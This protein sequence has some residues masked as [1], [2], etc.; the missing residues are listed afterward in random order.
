[1]R[2]IRSFINICILIFI[3]QINLAAQNKVKIIGQFVDSISR[4][5]IGKVSFSLYQN[6]SIL[7]HSLSNE[8]GFF[9]LNI[10]TNSKTFKVRFT[11][12]NYLPRTV[13][14][15][16]Q[17][18]SAL[19]LGIIDLKQ[20]SIS[21]K[22]VNIISNST[23]I[24]EK[25]D[26]TLTA[27]FS[28]HQFKSY[29][30]T[31]KAL[32]IIPGI[33]VANSKVYLNGVEID[34]IRVGDRNFIFDK[35]FL[36]Q[37]LPGFTIS[38]VKIIEMT[39]DFGRKYNR[40]N[41]ILKSVDQSA[42]LFNSNLSKGTNSSNWASLSS[43]RIDSLYQVGVRI[44]HNNINIFS[45]AWDTESLT[46]PINIPGLNMLTTVDISAFYQ[47]DKKTS[48]DFKY[49]NNEQNSKVKQENSIINLVSKD[50][51]E[52]KLEN[53][54]EN[55]NEFQN[56]NFLTKKK[57]NHLT[58]ISIGNETKISD[59]KS[60]NVSNFFINYSNLNSTSTRN[61]KGKDVEF[62]LNIDRLKKSQK[63]PFFNLEVRAEIKQ[64]RNLDKLIENLLES[65][66][67]RNVNISHAEASYKMNLNIGKSILLQAYTNNN[68]GKFT[69]DDKVAGS[70]NVDINSLQSS[71]G[72]KLVRKKNNS[73]I[74]IDLSHITYILK[75]DSYN[76]THINA[77]SSNINYSNQ[78]KNRNKISVTFSNDYSLPTVNQITGIPNFGEQ[79]ILNVKSNFDL[80]P[81]KRYNFGITYSLKTS[82]TLDV[83]T[84]YV[85]NKI[86][87][88]FIT[89]P[90]K[91]PELQYINSNGTKG[92][93][94]NLS[95]TKKAS[96]DE[97]YITGTIG[98]KYSES[99]YFS[100][101]GTFPNN[102]FS[103]FLN[104]TYNYSPLK[105]MK[106]N[107]ISEFSTIYYFNVNQSRNSTLSNTVLT[108][109]ELGDRCDISAEFK[110]RNY[111][112]G[113]DVNMSS[114]IINLIITNKLFASRS[115]GVFVSANNI[116]NSDNGQ[117]ILSSIDR[118][119]YFKTNSLGRYFLFGINYKISTFK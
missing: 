54:I 74:N 58:S 29:V 101:A 63:A 36:L 88:I 49:R 17:K 60:N 112:S 79:P 91:L 32:Q 114:R 65:T 90:T 5:G 28:K 44:Q 106:L 26:D 14:I 48:I 64:G 6:D 34:D 109:Y 56:F 53:K 85:Q 100:E 45:D 2:L 102:V 76:N 33:K 39:D 47:I 52:S 107:F 13:D 86:E 95:Y 89:N 16:L 92:L 70:N 4:D 21:L 43:A 115:F 110:L 118:L 59:N 35:N 87:N 41:I 61:F 67:N 108:R 37:N 71:S 23:L 20:N 66:T 50:N 98:S 84:Y 73:S 94:F 42:Y 31:N 93:T 72:F 46:T 25:H 83:K 55:K 1:M 113:N 96:K 117:L 8:N 68:I 97:M 9:N 12:I 22:E 78:F 40:I 75:N 105:T 15:V 116:L 81:E 80:N 62:F 10:N 19:D 99:N 7:F 18:N 3:F 82:F 11:H 30:M 69:S 103:T 57:L 77:L 111:M 38:K 51:V 24:I 27:D 119:Q 104:L